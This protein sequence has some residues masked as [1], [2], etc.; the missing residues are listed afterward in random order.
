[1]RNQIVIYTQ[2]LYDCVTFLDIH[3]SYILVP[4]GLRDLTS[5]VALHKTY[6]M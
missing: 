1:M 4:N 5:S 6:T 3:T 2:W